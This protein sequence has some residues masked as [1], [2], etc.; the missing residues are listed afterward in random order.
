M[1]RRGPI[2]R[3]RAFARKYA[4]L[5]K[6]HWSEML[7]YRSESLIWMIGAFVQPIVSLCVWVSV[8]ADRAINGFAIADYVLY[9]TG[10]MFVTRMTAAWDVWGVD[11]EI[12]QGTYSAKLLRPFH[13]IHWAMA[14]NLT[15]KLFS[16]ALMVPAWIVLAVFFPAMRLPAEPAELMLALA[17]LAVAFLIRFL[18]GYQ[19]GLLAFWTTRAGAIYMLYESL[20]LFLSGRIAPLAMSPEWVQTVAQWLPF[21]VTIGFPIELAMDRI[22]GWPAIAQGF[23]VQFLWLALLLLLFRLEWALGLRRYGAVGG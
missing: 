17:A 21:Y 16:A 10:V 14:G 5:L 12:R 9:F 8:S 1:I 19:I 23:A 7:I 20:H 6:A 2:H 3:V 11:N 22:A 4:A 15:Y 13:P 18:I